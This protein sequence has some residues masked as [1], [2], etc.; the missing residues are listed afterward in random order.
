VKRCGFCLYCG[1]NGEGTEAGFA[2][3]PTGRARSPLRAAAAKGLAALPRGD[4]HA[5]HFLTEQ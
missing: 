4:T 2:R 5:S 3:N 1:D